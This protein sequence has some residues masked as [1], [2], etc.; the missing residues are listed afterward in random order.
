VARAAL[1]QDVGEAAG[2]RTDVEREAAGRVDP[3]ASRAAASL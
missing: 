1:E 2:R 3:K